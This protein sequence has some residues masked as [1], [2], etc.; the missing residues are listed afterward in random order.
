V[1]GPAKHLTKGVAIYGAGD[2]I[3]QVV[4]FG[5]LPVYVK[6]NLLTTTDYGVLLG[7]GAVEAF[8]KVIN[9]WGLDGAFMR[10][11]LDRDEGASRRRLASTIVWFLL[12]TNG[13][14]LAATLAASGFVAGLLHIEATQL[15]AFRIMLLNIF[16]VSF[17]FFPF[18]VMRLQNAAITY[19]GFTFARSVGTV[20]FRVLFVILLHMGITGVYLSDLAMTAVLLPLLWRW[21]R[22]LVGMAFSWDELRTVLR[23]GLPRLPHGLA[24]QWLENGPKLMLKRQISEAAC[25]VYQ[26]GSAL[27]SAVRFFTSAFETA[28]A[29]F[30]YATSRQPDAKQ[31]FG[32]M[33]TYGVAVLVLLVAGTTAVA[34]DVIL[35]VLRPEYLDALPVVPTIAVA[36][37]L[38]G[39]YLLTSI[40]LNL[41]SRTEFYPAAT[42]TAAGVGFVTGLCLIPAY[43][44]AGAAATVL[45]SYLTQLVVAFTFA[46]RFYPITYEVG[47]LLR[48]VLAGS[49][50]AFVGLRLLPPMTPWLG[51]LA[52][53]STVVGLY[54]GLLWLTGFFRP[55]ERAFLREMIG[56]LRRRT[57]GPRTP[58][59]DD[60]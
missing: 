57:S 35:L 46:Q 11:Y 4:N 21:F 58:P 51:V 38:Q 32:K 24:L 55:T 20:A 5:L 15:T 1:R 49:I 13:L 33:A 31:V 39:V 10:Y 18:H 47:R 29:P 56:R 59:S 30:Y 19:S 8:A 25:G 22:P 6:L 53:G 60:L 52:R 3:M 54:A 28:W 2:A 27:G 37:A 36:V 42:L 14:L 7:I 9:R 50:A 12:A 48:L 16:L 40:G 43:G 26:N 23:F 44:V 34:H 45:I 17:T 41:T